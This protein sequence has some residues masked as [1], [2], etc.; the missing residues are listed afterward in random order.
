LGSRV[1]KSLGIGPWPARMGWDQPTDRH[2]S[3][4]VGS[5]SHIQGRLAGFC[6]PRLGTGLLHV[7]TGGSAHL[8]DRISLL[9]RRFLEQRLPEESTLGVVGFPARTAGSQVWVAQFSGFR[10]LLSSSISSLSLSGLHLTFSPTF[11]FSSQLTLSCFQLSLPVLE[12]E[13]RINR[14]RKIE[15][16]K[17]NNEGSS[18]SPALILTLP[19]LSAREDG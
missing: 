6:R 9:L 11:C 14:R 15:I 13:G 10:I 8:D 2:G 12:E 3:S 5:K 16:R 1:Y 4:R 17:E 7:T 19:L 18:L